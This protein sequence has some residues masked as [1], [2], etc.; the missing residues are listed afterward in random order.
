M[1][2]RI[3][4]HTD[5]WYAALDTYIDE[6]RGAPFEWGVNDC[7]SFAADWVQIATGVDPMAE[8]RGLTSALAAHRALERMGGMLAVVEQFCGPHIPGPFAQVGDLAM[9]TLPSGHKAMAV[10]IGPWL[11]APSAHGGLSMI[12]VD[13][14]E[15]AWRV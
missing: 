4:R 15:A 10:C 9:V 6:R 12:P 8:L 1:T 11:T 14:A 13:A 7:C 5:E 3:E 2:N